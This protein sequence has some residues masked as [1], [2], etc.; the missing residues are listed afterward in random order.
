[1]KLYCRDA[2]YYMEILQRDP[3]KPNLLLMHG[4]MGSSKGFAPLAE[5][6]KSIC[7]PCTIDL[8]GHGR[9]KMP[10]DPDRF[11]AESQVADF[12]SIL[13]RLQLDNL[14]L[15][16]YSMGGR[17]AQN[18]FSDSSER[19]TGLILESTHCG[20]SDGVKRQQ[21]QAIDEKRAKA[22]ES[23]FDNFIEKWTKLPLFVSPD[24][25]R[26]FD[27][28]SIIKQQNPASM[29]ASLRG[30]GAG[31][32]PYLCDKL[33]ASDV[34]IALIAGESDEKYVDKMREIHHLFPESELLVANSAGHRVHADQPEQIITFLTNFL[35]RYG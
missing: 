6:L 26:E 29:A 30:F 28:D 7:N 22:I 1:M 34:P 4:F 17:L 27:Y 15:Y 32:T 31:S 9:S 25:A 20:I 19:F 10:A 2:V 8:A 24:S 16:G 14:W 18:L 23:D 33:A 12:Q 5:R 13:D 3:F 11:S 35:N 21:R